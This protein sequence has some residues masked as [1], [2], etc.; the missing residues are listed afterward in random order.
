MQSIPLGRPPFFPPVKAEL[1][2]HSSSSCAVASF[3]PMPVPACPGAPEPRGCPDT[4]A[5]HGLRAKAGCKPP[6]ALTQSLLLPWSS[7][8]SV[9]S[10]CPAHVSF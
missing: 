8:W 6:S 2:A 7:H 4:M 3:H 5:L 9:F 10:C 1:R